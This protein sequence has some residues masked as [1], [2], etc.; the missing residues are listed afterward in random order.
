MDARAR[1]IAE[2]VLAPCAARRD[3]HSDQPVLWFLKAY[4]RIKGSAVF[5]INGSHGWSIRLLPF[6]CNPLA[7]RSNIPVAYLNSTAFRTCSA[8]MY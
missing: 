7:I 4:L 2:N 8:S 1:E 6:N 5:C 3:A